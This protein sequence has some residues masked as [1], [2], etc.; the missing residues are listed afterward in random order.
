MSAVCDEDTYLNRVVG[1]VSIILLLSACSGGTKWTS[2][3][4]ALIGD[5]AENISTDS[6]R[7]RQA[8]KK[9]KLVKTQGKIY[10][11]NESYMSA[12]GQNCV[13]TNNKNNIN[14]NKTFCKNDK[15]WIDVGSI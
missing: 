8:R 15:D 5:N 9:I 2:P 13:K 6:N 4:T 12:L 11:V 3:K 1:A 14:E 10:I 7:T